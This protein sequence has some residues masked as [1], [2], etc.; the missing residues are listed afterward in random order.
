MPSTYAHYR[1]GVE[2]LA[3]MPADVR[4]SVQRFRRLYDVGLH[5]PDLFFY[6]NPVVKTRIGGL[7]SRFHDQSGQEFFTRVCRSLRLSPSEAG[8]A[9]LYGVLC[10]YCLDSICHPFVIEKTTGGPA[11]HVELET[12]FD[13]FLLEADGKTPP[14]A[15]DLSPHIRLTPGECE[16]AAA[17]Y[18]SVTARHIRDCVRNMAFF[19]RLL[20]APEGAKRDLLNKGMALAGH[21]VEGMLMPLGPNPRCADLDEPLL[22]LY[23]KAAALYPILLGQIQA[24]MAYGAPL[25]PEFT[26]NFG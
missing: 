22:A 14:C 19:T 18:P 23:R 4:R 5:G 6:Y 20:A 9:Y 25:G 24:H 2:M 13:R 17:F 26:A 1:F 11:T 8:T 7:G 3:D 15:Q 16:T 12:E 10:H 21:D